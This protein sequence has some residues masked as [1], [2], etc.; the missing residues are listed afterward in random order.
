MSLSTYYLNQRISNLQAEINALQSGGLPTSS[1]L[2]VVLTNGNSAGTNDIDMNFNSIQNIDVANFID[3]TS[4]TTTGI[5][6]L[7]SSISDLTG[8]TQRDNAADKEFVTITNQDTVTGFFTQSQMSAG[9]LVL[10]NQLALAESVTMNA[11]NVSY[12][13]GGTVSATWADIISG[14]AT[15]NTLDEVL[16]AGN[17]SSNTFILNNAGNANGQ[18]G[19]QIVLDGQG[20]G[21]SFLAS[22]TATKSSINIRDEDAT[23]S[24][25][26]DVTQGSLGTSNLQFFNQV[27]FGYN[28]TLTM[29]LAN[30]TASSGISHTDF[31]PTPS[32]FTIDTNTALKLKATDTA[33]QY[34]YGIY[35]DPATPSLYYELAPILGAGSRVEINNSGVISSVLTSSQTAGQLSGSTVFLTNAATQRDMT[36]NEGFIN[37]ASTTAP[38]LNST[39]TISTI[40]FNDLAGATPVSASLGVTALTINNPNQGTSTINAGEATFQ[41]ASAGGQANPVLILNNTNATG[42]VA[43]EIYKAKPTAA[44]NGDVLFT[45]SVYGKD[46]GNAKQEFTRINH[47]VRDITAGVEDGSI[48]FGCFVNG[49]VTTFLQINGNENDIN[50]L[51]PLD[52]NVP[53]GASASNATIKLSGT[54]STDLEINGSTSNG[55]GHINI[56]SKTGT[57]VNVANSILINAG[58]ST[59]AGNVTITPKAVGGYLILNNLPTSVVGLPTGAVWNNLGV[60]NI[61]P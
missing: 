45:Q 40:L 4:T 44:V 1:D 9:G 6:N 26:P 61:A 39:H 17:T 16:A 32:P 56:T 51:R 19:S 2:A 48:E 58:A 55:T 47:T 59:G 34:G 13:Q 18:S 15:S 52:F 28:D 21:A 24:P 57:V 14:S 5:N 33:V 46:S 43:M 20:S 30:S 25:N 7:G 27:P 42:S 31:F 35:I 54:N 60:L 3:P 49:A 36:L 29:S 22:N 12:T 50:M 38:S 41:K 10:N 37:F 53:S 23:T 11:N 8:T